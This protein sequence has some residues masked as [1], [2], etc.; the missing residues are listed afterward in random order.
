[1][2][3]PSDYAM[4]VYAGVL[5]KIIAVYAGKPFE[6]WSYQAI[7]EKFGEINYYVHEQVK[8]PL[9]AA[10]DDIS[11]TFCFLRALPD[12]GNVKSLT[13]EQIG[14]TWLNY[15]VEEKT[16]LWWGGMGMSTE[17]T[18]YLRLKH[19]MKA[20]ATGSIAT[21]GQVVA[22]QIGAQIFIDGWAMVVPGD[23]DLAVELAGRAA[24]VSHDGEAVYGAQ[25]IA[26][27]ESMAFVERDIDKL[28][29][30]GL[31]RIPGDCLI[32]RMIADIRKWRK[33]DGDWRKTR[34][35]IEKNYGY[36][37]YGGNCHIIPNHALI[38]LALLYGEGDFGRSV[39][40]VNTCGWDTDCNSGN[41]G[42]IIGI[43]NGLDGFDPST[44]AAPFAQDRILSEEPGDKSNGFATGR[45]WRGPVAD[46]ALIPTADGGRCV[47]DALTEAYHVVNIGRALAGLP[48]EAP[49]NGARFHFEA[50]GAVQGFLAEKSPETSGVASVSNSA[51]HSKAGTRSLAI[52]YHGLA[53]G[54]TARVGVDTFLAPES[55][56]GAGYSLVA[57]P[58]MYP[59]QKVAAAVS[60]D[61]TNS[62]PIRCRLFLRHYG[63][64]DALVTVAGPEEMLAPG[65]G[66]DFAWKVPDTGGQPIARI[67][68]EM[69]SDT[70]AKG[71]V[72]LDYLAWDGAPETRLWKPEKEGTAW[73]K[74]WVNAVSDFQHWGG[75]IQN[76]GRG[77]LIQGAREWADYTVTA[78]VSPHLAEKAG[79]AARVQGL[80]RYY[81]L[82][83]CR[84]GKVRLI[85]ALDGDRTLAEAT[86]AMEFDAK[87]EMKLAV[88]GNRV[89]GWVNGKQVADAVDTDRP[90]TGGAVA[91]VIEEGRMQVLEVGVGP[92]DR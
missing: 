49:K 92:A 80:K 68:L 11:G 33:E 71:S 46:R 61:S 76:E 55:M 10:D 74:A 29:D 40:I 21:N 67:G 34:E 84:D 79:I 6:G 52:A 48:P 20:P 19:G 83:L 31:A 5:G 88:K 9:I 65:A 45:D 36:D 54:K 60:A 59:G 24:R 15:L 87:Y 39:M 26:A 8:Y 13:S 78:T 89:T 75:V 58:T 73:T 64:K 82:L 85:K 63:D 4:R 51:G 27:I 50:P 28:V 7:M 38:I 22:E 70:P 35:K 66:K 25:V 77:M 90:L 17:H 56:G 62:G 14:Q 43:R 18:A 3:I 72:Y 81:A 1:M 57:S 37:K 47:T 23:P 44:R 53:E 30:A 91:L 69:L 42:C 41:V 32:A 16:V 86:L 2:P 12:Y